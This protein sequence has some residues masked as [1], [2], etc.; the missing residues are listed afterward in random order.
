MSAVLHSGG[1]QHARP[2]TTSGLP[3]VLQKGKGQYVTVYDRATGAEMERHTIID[4]LGK[5]FESG[6]NSKDNPSGGVSQLTNAQAA[7]ELSGGG[8]VAYHPIVPKG[9]MATDKYLEQYGL[10]ASAANA[11]QTQNIQGLINAY[12]KKIEEAAEK[13]L[14]ALAKHGDTLLTK[15]DNASQNGSVTS[16]EKALGTNTNAVFESAKVRHDQSVINSHKSTG[17]QWWNATA[18]LHDLQ[19]GNVD[20]AKAHYASVTKNP[21]STAA[22]QWN[23]L[24]GLYDAQAAQGKNRTS[25]QTAQSV[26]NSKLSRLGA[27]ASADQINKA[28]DPTLARAQSA[29]FR[30]SSS[31]RWS[32]SFAARTSPR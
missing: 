23:A 30:P 4:V 17:Y 26:L 13:A 24:Q 21:K 3:G 8:F 12:L 7:G 25:T 11:N 29:V 22:E 27:G 32:L 28:L 1:G 9:P 6:G 19:Y 10:S 5:F 31:T 18:N 15:Y 16:L 2:L 20:K 14:E